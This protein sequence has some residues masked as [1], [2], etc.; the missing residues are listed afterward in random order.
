MIIFLSILLIAMLIS[1][2]VIKKHYIIKVVFATIF[3]LIMI[4][5][6][7]KVFKHPYIINIKPF[8]EELHYLNENK[9]DSMLI[10]NTMFY[11][12][13]TL[14]K[15]FFKEIN[16]TSVIESSGP[17]SAQNMIFLSIYY[18]NEEIQFRYFSKSIKGELIHVMAKIPITY[19]RLKKNI[20]E[21]I[22]NIL[23]EDSLRK[24]NTKP[25]STI[26]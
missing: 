17:L 2:K 9:I 8:I 1:F 5:F 12:G 10:E 21:D 4:R 3:I 15:P 20:Y 25:H 16:N 26:P 23:K 13:D 14:L 19:F 18:K 11:K 22:Q 24:L 6:I 7:T